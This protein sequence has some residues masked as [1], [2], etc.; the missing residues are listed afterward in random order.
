[1]LSP[2]WPPRL[3]RQLGRVG[4]PPVRRANPKARGHVVLIDAEK[5]L[6]ARGLNRSLVMASRVG[7]GAAMVVAGAV[8]VMLA[9]AEQPGAG[10]I[11]GET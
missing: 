8:M 10:A 7:V 11:H 6:T 3:D 1:L 9:S 2:V 5:Q 4:Q